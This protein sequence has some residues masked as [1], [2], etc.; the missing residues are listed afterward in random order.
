[1]EGSFSLF[2]CAVFR[3][4]ELCFGVSDLPLCWYACLTFCVFS[5]L[6]MYVHALFCLPHQRSLCLG[7]ACGGWHRESSLQ[8][9]V[10]AW[11]LL[12]RVVSALGTSRIATNTGLYLSRGLLWFHQPHKHTQIPCVQGTRAGLEFVQVAELFDK[13]S[14]VGI[15]FFKNGCYWGCNSTDALLKAVSV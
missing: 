8:V 12:G 4:T 6:F 13:M 5:A 7:V 3:I 1:M 14:F 9:L 10:P 11:S 2:Y 15:H